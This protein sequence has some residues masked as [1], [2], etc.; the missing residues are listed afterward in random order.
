[1]NRVRRG[2]LFV[3]AAAVIVAAAGMGLVTYKDES[4]SE[5]AAY[6]RTSLEPARVLV[7]AYSRSGHTL[8]A[9]KEAARYFDADLVRIEAPAYPRSFGGQR[10]ASTDA[11][12]QVTATEI[13][14]PSPSID[15]YDLVV[16]ASPTWWFRPAV[17]LWAFVEETDFV[18]RPVF[19][20]MTGNSRYELE[21][22]ERF[23]DR[24]ADK[25]GNL[26]GHHFIERG[27]VYWQKS[28]DEVQTEVREALREQASS[29]PD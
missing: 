27:R 2:A 3:L 14:Y 18:G 22:V 16:L 20:L 8:A 15:R 24:V 17:P 13:H 21:Q 28:D 12:A 25:N 23:A 6:A 7:V 26:I 29:F 5:S 4:W 11:D 19:L 10:K 1:M 9:A